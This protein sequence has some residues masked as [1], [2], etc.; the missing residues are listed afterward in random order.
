MFD[1]QTV[2]TCSSDPDWVCNLGSI[3]LR[4][5]TVG[6]HLSEHF[7][8]GGSLDN[9]N[10]QINWSVTEVVI[11]KLAHMHERN[12]MWI[13]EWAAALVLNWWHAAV[14]SVW[15]ISW[16]YGS[17]SKLLDTVHVASTRMCTAI[18]WFPFPLGAYGRLAVLSGWLWQLLL[19]LK[20][21]LCP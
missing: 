3:H 4:S 14:T 12:C 10:V 5:S 6:S 15:H 16:L 19:P 2:Y 20:H 11:I 17:G 1:L 21:L 13:V 7:G 18:A 9:W 8:T